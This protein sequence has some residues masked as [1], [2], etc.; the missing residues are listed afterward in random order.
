[1]IST[2]LEWTWKPNRN[3]AQT[4]GLPAGQLQVGFVVIPITPEGGGALLTPA[5][6]E[7][8]HRT[9]KR[10]APCPAL[11]RAAVQSPRARGLS[12]DYDGGGRRWRR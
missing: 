12:R 7:N 1:M 10:P 6:H 11:A 5:E 8:T 2:F 3:A 9:P 4:H